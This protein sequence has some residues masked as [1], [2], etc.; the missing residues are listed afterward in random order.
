M[1]VDG[2]EARRA[3]AEHLAPYFELQLRF[4]GELAGRAGLPLGAAVTW[5]TNLHRRFGHGDVGARES[6][7]A[8]TTFLAAVED[9][10]KLEEQVECAIDAFVAGNDELAVPGRET[11]GCFGFDP[12]GASGEV[13]IHFCNRDSA[14]GTSPLTSGKIGRRTAELRTMFARVRETHPTARTVRGGSWLY[15]LEAYR[16]LFPPA[17]VATR[18]PVEP[19][20]RTGTSSWGQ[21]L[22][23]QERVKAT[24]RDAVIA[25]LAQLDPAVPWRAFPQR[26][27][28]TSAP[29]AVFY[30]HYDRR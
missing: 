13:R 29:L 14:D 25:N 15:H 4:A 22:D 21:V 27:L 5:C 2:D 30:Q 8:W 3:R 20:R 6:P 19:V 26:P 11:V 9:A 18:T 24:V 23:S 16:R 17:F 12:P 28:R 1:R 10:N 7:P